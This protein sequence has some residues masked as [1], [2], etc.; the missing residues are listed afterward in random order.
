MKAKAHNLPAEGICNQTQI[1]E[2]ITNNDIGY[3]AYP[4]LIRCNRDKRFD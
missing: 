4:K 3:I 1:T 2:A